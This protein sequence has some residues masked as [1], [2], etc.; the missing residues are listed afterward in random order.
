MVK[1]NLESGTVPNS[2]H[3]LPRLLRGGAASRERVTIAIYVG[4][5][6]AHIKTATDNIIY[7]KA[8][9]YPIFILDLFI[10]I[11]SISSF[12]KTLVVTK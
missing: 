2:T 9:M 11:I 5:P 6:I 10:F 8:N 4:N 7:V 12:L 1:W 3:C